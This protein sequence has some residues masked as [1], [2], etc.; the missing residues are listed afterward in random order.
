MVLPPSVDGRV[1]HTKTL[2]E[3]LI[4]RSALGACV[5]KKMRIIDGRHSGLDCQVLELLKV[6][7]GH[8]GIHSS[9]PLLFWLAIRVKVPIAVCDY[10]SNT[11]CIL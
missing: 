1:R 11:L 5:R 10:F 8:S 6:Q 2:D 9:T 3:K 7:K 4:P